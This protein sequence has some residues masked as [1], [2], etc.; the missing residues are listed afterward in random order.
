VRLDPD[1][2]GAHYN[3]GIAFVYQGQ[4]DEAARQYGEAI[5]SNPDYAEAHNNLGVALDSKDDVEGARREFLA[6]TALRFDLILAAD[7]FIYVGD[8]AAVFR[9][10]RRILEPGGCLAFTVEP[11]KTGQDIQLL[12]SLRYAHSQTYVQRLAQAHIEVEMLRLQGYRSLTNLLRT[13]H[14]GNESSMEKVLGSETDQRLQEL[15]MSLF[16]PYGALREGALS[17]GEGTIPRQFLYARS[18]T[19]MGGTSE[20]QRNVIAQRILGLPR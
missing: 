4:L 8:L 1:S 13:G 17:L 12:P 7:V 11:A 15:A 16:G 14:P 10:V 9:S 19:I 3:L 18:E 2:A 5:R 6:A 20:I